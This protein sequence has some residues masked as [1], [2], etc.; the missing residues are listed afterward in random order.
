MPVKLKDY[1]SHIHGKGQVS[2]V[3]NI[4][5]DVSK[6]VLNHEQYSADYIHSLNN[7]MKVR[8]PICYKQACQEEE[9]RK[10]MDEELDALEK[11]MT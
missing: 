8:E 7:A 10:A 1:D 9:W 5:D 2:S 6:R 4:S 3:T 11:N